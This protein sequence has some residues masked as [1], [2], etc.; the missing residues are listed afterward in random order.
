[1]WIKDRTKTSM[2]IRKHD[3]SRNKYGSW[4]YLSRQYKK[5][6]EYTCELTN[7]CSTVSGDLHVHHIISVIVDP[8]LGL[9]R[10]NLMLIKADIHRLFHREYGTKTTEDEWSSFLKSVNYN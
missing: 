10:S 4:Q 1:M 6:K 9:D 3:F 5:E 2:Y 8:T 7:Y